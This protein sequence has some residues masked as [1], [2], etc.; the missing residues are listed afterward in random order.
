M[1]SLRV[2]FL[3]DK[4]IKISI[5]I[6]TIMFIFSVV[7]GYI[8]NLSFEKTNMYP[9]FTEIFINNSYISLISIVGIISLGLISV[10]LL[11]INGF[12]LGSALHYSI[13]NSGILYTVKILL[14]HS[15]IEIPSILLSTSIGFILILYI[16][17]KSHFKNN[18]RFTYYIKYILVCAPII[19]IINLIAAL[20]EVFISM[21]K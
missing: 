19:L 21:P 12:Y 9:N 4:I 18:F 8:I 14:P 16:I 3:K 20:I 5:L 17:K 1:E 13:D 6:S 10:I 15:I 2:P 11:F 7:L